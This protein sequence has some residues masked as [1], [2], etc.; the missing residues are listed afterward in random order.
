MQRRKL[1][2]G[3]AATGVFLTIAGGGLALLRP[4]RIK[5]RLSAGSSAVMSA[6]GQTVLNGFLP[7]EA[8]ARA[9]E[10]QAHLSRLQAT[11]GGFPPALQGEVDE[12]LGMLAHPAGRVALFGM[13]ADW[14]EAKPDEVHAAMRSLQASG[15]GLR[16]QVFQ[17]LRDLTNAAYFADA[18]TWAQL[19][20][21]GP[22]AV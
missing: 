16:Q 7:T 1:L 4:A 10:L 21:P 15:A 18:S 6:V 13:S 17:A 20:Y 19:G 3:G 8:T 22:R 5:G 11:I 14:N 12:L 9:V 2:V